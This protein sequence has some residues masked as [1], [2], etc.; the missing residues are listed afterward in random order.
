VNDRDRPEL[1]FEA[2]SVYFARSPPGSSGGGEM[3]MSLSKVT[4]AALLGSIFA[5]TAVV[6]A[7]CGT[8]VESDCNDLQTAKTACGATTTLT[9]DQCADQ[10][11][12]SANA[13]CDDQAAALYDCLS[14]LTNPCE[15]SEVAL[16]ST[17]TDAFATCMC[18]YCKD[19]ASEAGCKA[20]SC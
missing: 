14:G 3:E 11:T 15:Q 18:A 4:G 6:A 19:H 20:R 7:G 1:G 17:S 8:S 10:A 13:A 9:E 5:M 2:L 12:T 16:C